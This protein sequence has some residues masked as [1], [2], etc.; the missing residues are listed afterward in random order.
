LGDG[1]HRIGINPW[2]ASKTVADA[3]EL[4]PSSATFASDPPGQQ[5]LEALHD[6]LSEML[7]TGARNC[8]SAP[9]AELADLG[10]RLG[11]IRLI[12]PIAKLADGLA[13]L[14]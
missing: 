13:S 1:Q 14:E 12:D 4:E 9:M 7:L 8:S 10:R 3:A 11:F 5:F 6:G 2:V